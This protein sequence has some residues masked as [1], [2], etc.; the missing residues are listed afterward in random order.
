MNDSSKDLPF[1]PASI[2]RLIRGFL[3]CDKDGS[4]DLPDVEAA[5]MLV[6]NLSADSGAA[7]GEHLASAGCTRF[8]LL[9]LLR[10]SL[11]D[12]SQDS[13]LTVSRPLHDC[14]A[15]MR[16]THCCAASPIITAGL[17]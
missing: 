10:D 17:N 15:N 7:A 16:Q 3:A 11:T 9:L 13:P 12:E 2:I 5:G 8:L 1:E 6:W 4:D 14:A